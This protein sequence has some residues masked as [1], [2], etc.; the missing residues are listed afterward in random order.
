MAANM[1]EQGSVSN[2]GM[3]PSSTGSPVDST[4]HDPDHGNH[5]DIPDTGRLGNNSAPQQFGPPQA[6][7]SATQAA[8]SP[9]ALPERV[10]INITLN[11]NG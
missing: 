11:I 9:E 7:G 1:P 6:T 2:P 5:A 10:V 3:A 8:P 4:G